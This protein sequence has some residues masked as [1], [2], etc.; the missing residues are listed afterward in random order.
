MSRLDSSDSAAVLVHAGSAQLLAGDSVQVAHEG[1]LAVV[2][3]ASSRSATPSSSGG[4]VARRPPST[5]C[6]APSP[7]CC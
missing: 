6:M 7:P 1:D 2:P 5:A 4:T 3:R